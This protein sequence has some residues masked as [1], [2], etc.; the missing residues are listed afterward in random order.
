M[1]FWAATYTLGKEALVELQRNRMTSS[2]TTTAP[3]RFCIVNC[4]PAA[5]RENFD[6][7]DVG[8]PHDMFKDFLRREAPN[9]TTELV[10]VADPDFALPADTSISASSELTG[11][12]I[13]REGETATRAILIVWLWATRIRASNPRSPLPRS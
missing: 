12:R 8:H 5:S 13:K 4:Y 10:F 6:R 7:S 3:H 1:R 9:A 2:P 11:R